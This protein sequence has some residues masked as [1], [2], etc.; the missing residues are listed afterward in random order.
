MVTMASSERIGD[1][2]AD[3]LMAVHLLRC[4]RLGQDQ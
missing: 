1:E 3:D 4:D 2:F